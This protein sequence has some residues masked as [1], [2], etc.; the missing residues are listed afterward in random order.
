MRYENLP[1]PFQKMFQLKSVDERVCLGIVVE[2]DER[3]IGDCL[4]LLDERT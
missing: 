3:L 1:L 4:H 2:D